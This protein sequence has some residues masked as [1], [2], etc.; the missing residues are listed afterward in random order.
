[1]N[2]ART[3]QVRLSS[4]TDEG[5]ILSNEDFPV[6]FSFSHNVYIVLKGGSRFNSFFCGTCS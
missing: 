3:L 4:C 6:H 1:M 2:D 5:E